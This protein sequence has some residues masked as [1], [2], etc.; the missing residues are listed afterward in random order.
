MK[1][2]EKMADNCNYHQIL[3]LPS[4]YC[5]FWKPFFFFFGNLHKHLCIPRIPSFW[6]DFLAVSFVVDIELHSNV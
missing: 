3:L 2:N 4:L 1:E 6:M 5:C